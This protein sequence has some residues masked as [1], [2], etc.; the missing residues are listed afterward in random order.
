MAARAEKL[1]A[2]E[3]KSSQET[4][5]SNIKLNT[6]THIDAKQFCVFFLQTCFYHYLP[7][8]LSETH[9]HTQNMQ[10]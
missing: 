1:S 10:K 3:A 9:T 7:L 8:C 2:I 4:D 6:Q 5:T